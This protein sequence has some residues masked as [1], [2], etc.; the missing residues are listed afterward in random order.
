ML[1]SMSFDKT[2]KAMKKIKVTLIREVEV[3]VVLDET[4]I[5]ESILDAI[6]EQFDDEI[7]KEPESCDDELS[8]YE[9]GLYNY[10]RHAAIVAVGFGEVEFI[11]LERNHTTAHVVDD[12]LS[13]EFDKIVELKT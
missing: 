6:S 8:K 2:K 1:M 7:Y 4:V 10:A 9:C 3:E 5:D 11:N 13:S 12:Y